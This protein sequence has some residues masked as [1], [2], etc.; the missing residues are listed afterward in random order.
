MND[1]KYHKMFK[2]KK[3]RVS[4]TYLYL[5]LQYLVVLKVLIYYIIFF[6]NI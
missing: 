6:F 2:K 1:N 3:I 4:I 5:Y